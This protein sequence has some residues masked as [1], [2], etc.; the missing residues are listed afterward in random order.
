MTF[1]VK[2]VKF[3]G[4]V[5]ETTARANEW[6]FCVFVEVGSAWIVNICLTFAQID[7]FSFLSFFWGGLIIFL[8][9]G[10]QT[11]FRNYLE[12]QSSHDLLSHCR[13]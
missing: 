12:K 2:V 6:S 4:G 9:R 1:Q 5:A 7:A 10:S 11:S 13:L 3:Y 8:I